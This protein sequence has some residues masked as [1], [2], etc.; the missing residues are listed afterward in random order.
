M[1]KQDCL[2]LLDRHARECLRLYSKLGYVG[3]MIQE[4]LAYIELLE[5]E[6]LKEKP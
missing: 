3:V 2:A 6:L 1:E 4:A 5:A